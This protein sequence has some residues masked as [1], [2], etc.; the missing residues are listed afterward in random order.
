MLLPTTPAAP[1][2][3]AAGRASARI[4]LDPYTRPLGKASGGLSAPMASPDCRGGAGEGEG[5]G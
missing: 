5:E 1:P 4:A 3:P 2:I